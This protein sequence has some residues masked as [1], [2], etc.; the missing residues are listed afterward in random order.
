MRRLAARNPRRTWVGAGAGVLTRQ[1]APDLRG[2]RVHHYARA[3][4]AAVYACGLDFHLCA[5]P[6]R[7][8][9]RPRRRAG[10][11][12]LWRCAAHSRCPKR[13]PYALGGP[14]RAQPREPQHISR[15]DGRRLRATRP[16]RRASAIYIIYLLCE[17]ARNP[18]ERE[19]TNAARCG[20]CPAL[21]ED[22]NNQG[23]VAHP[24]ADN[25]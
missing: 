24:R 7:N 6:T 22:P 4:A 14:P 1:D 20:M 25:L 16:R 17:T 15:I 13:R 8:R 9:R 11:L 19:R 2:G 21:G 5:Q 10:E 18:P 23:L 3:D 12:Q